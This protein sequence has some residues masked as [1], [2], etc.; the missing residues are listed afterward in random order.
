MNQYHVRNYILQ[1]PTFD[2]L[3]LTFHSFPNNGRFHVMELRKQHVKYLAR[4]AANPENGQMTM[5]NN[6][7]MSDISF[8]W[9]YD[10]L[11]DRTQIFQ[12]AKFSKEV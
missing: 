7:K 9:Y 6:P 3:Y 11:L 8:V 1:I 5:E 10:R 12:N 2:W 4:K